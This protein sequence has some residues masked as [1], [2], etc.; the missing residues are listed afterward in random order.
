MTTITFP[1]VI[2]RATAGS[3]LPSL[4]QALAQGG[5]VTI[6]ARDVSRIG[7]AGL[8]LMLSTQQTAA[9]R[10]VAL[11]VQASIAMNAAAQIAGLAD[12]FKWAG[13][14]ND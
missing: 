13:S 12:I 9:A 11:T 14:T 1:P 10:G 5:P 3:L 8:Q 4:H 2:D 6:E 7:Q